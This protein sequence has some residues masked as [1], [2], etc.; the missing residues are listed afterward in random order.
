M[1]SKAAFSLIA[2]FLPYVKHF[3]MAF[4]LSVGQKSCNSCRDHFIICLI[5]GASNDESPLLCQGE[6]TKSPDLG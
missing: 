6:C 4:K 2:F 5:L 3:Q 1:T